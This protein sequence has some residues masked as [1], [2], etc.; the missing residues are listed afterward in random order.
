MPGEGRSTALGL[1]AAAAGGAVHD[2]GE[3]LAGVANR[4][5]DLRTSKSRIIGYGSI[6][7]NRFGKI[8][9]QRNEQ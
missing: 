2:R 8:V 3:D 7:R 5:E 1:V 9:E 6:S 4:G